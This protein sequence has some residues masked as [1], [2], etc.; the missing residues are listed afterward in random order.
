M[1]LWDAEILPSPLPRGGARWAAA[2]PSYTHRDTASCRNS[3]VGPAWFPSRLFPL[4]VSS[5]YQSN[6]GHNKKAI[7]ALQSWVDMPQAYKLA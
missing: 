1:K 7:M 4:S 5:P 3:P 6:Q 2:E